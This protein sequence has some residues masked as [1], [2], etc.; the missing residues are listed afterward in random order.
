[1]EQ[2]FERM[3][4]EPAVLPD[5]TTD[6]TVG[7]VTFDLTTEYGLRTHTKVIQTAKTSPTDL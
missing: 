7:A 4:M 3:G 2:E 6:D 5:K 1:M